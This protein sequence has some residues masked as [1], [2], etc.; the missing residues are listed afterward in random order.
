[1]VAY[2][3]LEAVGGWKD[4]QCAWDTAACVSGEVLHAR[5]DGLAGE[6]GTEPLWFDVVCRL[7]VGRGGRR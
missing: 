4:G 6:A 7:V 2:D 5:P 3:S 1:M